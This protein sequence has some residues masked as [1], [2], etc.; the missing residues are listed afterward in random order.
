MHA[1]DELNELAKSGSTD[2]AFSKLRELIPGVD[3]ICRIV[4]P[5]KVEYPE[6]LEVGAYTF[7]NNN[8]E[9]CSSGY[10]KIGKNCFIG[11]HAT[12]PPPRR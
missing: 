8:F 3:E 5:I 2:L 9:N 10:I 11:P 6:R 7:I 12:R 4:F 1:L